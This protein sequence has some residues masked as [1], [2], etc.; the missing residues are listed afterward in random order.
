MQLKV[1]TMVRV[2]FA[3]DAPERTGVITRGYR[4]H[5]G[6]MVALDPPKANQFE[7]DE[8]RVYGR[9]MT[10]VDPKL[11]ARWEADWA[12]SPFIDRTWATQPDQ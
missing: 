6:Y 3:P 7:P 8:V 11:R 4:K 1:G 5:G 12:K 2:K 9:A 10:P